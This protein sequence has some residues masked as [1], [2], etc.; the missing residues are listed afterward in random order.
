MFPLWFLTELHYQE[1]SLWEEFRV[2]LRGVGLK[3]TIL[4][5]SDTWMMSVT[6]SMQY[7]KT[8]RTTSKVPRPPFPSFPILLLQ[9]TRALHTP[10]PLLLLILCFT[11]TT[12]VSSQGRTEIQDSQ[13]GLDR[14]FMT[15][16]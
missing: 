5:S 9:A 13:W 15:L 4:I 10:S 11:L 12:L 6:R 8:G 1:T 3:E 14:S 7:A 2:L 16:L